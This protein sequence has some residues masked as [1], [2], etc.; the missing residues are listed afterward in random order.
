MSKN[1]Y[2]NKSWKD[3]AIDSSVKPVSVNVYYED[4][5][6]YLHYIGETTLTNGYHVQI[7]IPKMNLELNRIDC[8]WEDLPEYDGYFKVHMQQ[9]YVGYENDKEDKEKTW[10]KITPLE[11]TMTKEDIQKELGYK[12]NLVA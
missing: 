12:I 3:A 9:V 7:E 2:L 10:M 11:R 4:N 6:P 8:V 1:T 5:K